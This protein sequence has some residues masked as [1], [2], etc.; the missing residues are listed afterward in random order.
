MLGWGCTGV[1]CE[2]KLYNNLALCKE[3]IEIWWIKVNKIQ[4]S[5]LNYIKMTNMKANSNS[6]GGKTVETIGKHFLAFALI[7]H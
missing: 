3:E 4:Q 2:E 7:C 6:I 5:T 1:S